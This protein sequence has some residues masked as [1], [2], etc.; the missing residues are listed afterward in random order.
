MIKIVQE[1]LMQRNSAYGVVYTRLLRTESLLCIVC[2][3]FL[4]GPQIFLNLNGLKDKTDHV[5]E[6]DV[7]R[8]A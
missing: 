4:R 8:K 1:L 5:H 3:F 7:K 2:I 6:T